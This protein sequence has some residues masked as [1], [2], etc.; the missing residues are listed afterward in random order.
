M[1]HLP[2]PAIVRLALERLPTAS[3]VRH[4]TRS[5]PPLL[6]SRR[7]PF[8]YFPFTSM[9]HPNVSLSSRLFP[10]THP[11]LQTL[12]NPLPPPPNSPSPTSTRFLAFH[13]PT[14]IDRPCPILSSPSP[15]R[16]SRNLIHAS[17][18]ACLLAVRALYVPVTTTLGQLVCQTRYIQRT[19]RPHPGRPTPLWE[20]GQT[21]ASYS[22]P[23]R[24]VFNGLRP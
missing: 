10:C 9:F 11:F 12:S 6:V 22:R 1:L 2:K 19:V 23:Q 13:L 17:H 15:S 18:C 4:V 7:P 16:P 20:Q 8:L 21:R 14:P 5:H 3:S 24:F